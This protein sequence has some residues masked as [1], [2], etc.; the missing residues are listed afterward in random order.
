MHWLF[1]LL[2]QSVFRCFCDQV[3]CGH[4]GPFTARTGVVL[5]FGGRAR[6]R[7]D[8]A[9]RHGKDR[10]I[11]QPGYRWGR[12]VEVCYHLFEDGVIPPQVTVGG[13]LAQILYFRRG[14]RLFGLR[15]GEFRGARRRSPRARRSCALD[16]YRSSEQRS[17]HRSAVILRR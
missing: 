9:C 14:S 4:K 6:T 11:R 1:P 10:V 17:H 3:F 2:R 13:K 5:S 15:P 12:D 7:G 16:V 8:L